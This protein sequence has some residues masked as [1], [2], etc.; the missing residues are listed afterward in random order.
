M[1]NTWRKVLMMS[2]DI[3]QSAGACVSTAG[4]PQYLCPDFCSATQHS[5]EESRI[6]QHSE[7]SLEGAARSSASDDFSTTRHRTA[8]REQELKLSAS[9]SGAIGSPDVIFRGQQYQ[10]STSHSPT[11]TRR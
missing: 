9:T 6:A 8:R 7:P 5:A 10:H 2:T 3:I 11:N 4:A 1:R